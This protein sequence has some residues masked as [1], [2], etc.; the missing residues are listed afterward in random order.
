MPGQVRA[1]LV[2]EG[3]SVEKGQTL[4]LLEAIKMEIRVAAPHAG[5]VEKVLIEEGQVV[6]RGQR[7]FDLSHAPGPQG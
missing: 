4:A 2:K 5:K 1:V 3:E 7:L 6:E